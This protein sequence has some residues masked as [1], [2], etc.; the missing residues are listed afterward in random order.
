MTADQTGLATAGAAASG[1]PL[2]DVAIP[3]DIRAPGVAR[4]V[5]AGCLGGHVA[6][7]VIE[8][9]QLLVSELV[10]NSV[11]HSGVAPGDPVTV[12]VRVWDDACRLEVEDPGCQGVIAPHPSDPAKGTWMGLNLVQMLSEQWGVARATAGPTRVWAQLPRARTL[13]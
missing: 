7:P 13:A 3:L 2:A 1:G 8:D 10:T 4:R 11:L 9:A 12:R 5:V 6:A